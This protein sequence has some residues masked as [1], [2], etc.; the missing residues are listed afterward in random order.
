[1]TNSTRRAQRALIIGGSLGGLFTATTLRAIGWQVDVFERSPN[2]LDSRGGGIVLQADVEAAF[3]FAGVD[4]PDAL[5]VRSGDRIFLDKNDNVTR[6]LYMPQTQTS[7]NLL[8]GTLSRALPEGLVHRGESLVSVEKSPNGV[9]ARFASGRVETGD[10]LVGADGPMSAVRQLHL[11]DLVPIY[12]GYTARRGLAPENAVSARAER[13]L[14]GT[15]AFQD[16][17]GFQFL[18]YMVPGEDASTEV[19][20]RRWNWVWH[21]RLDLG[22]PYDDVMTDTQGR[23]RS[24]SIPP[25]SL[26]PEVGVRLRADAR[27]LLAPSFADLVE[28]T[29]EPFA[30]AILDLRVPRMVFDRTILLGDAAFVPR[31]HTAGGAAK[32]AANAV[33]LAEALKAFDSIDE[34]LAEWQDW[35]MRV[36]VEMCD[37]GIALGNSIVGLRGVRQHAL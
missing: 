27:E 36:G 17:P 19:G 11:P 20:R 28:A 26:R 13:T 10:L 22:A 21:R 23:R 2:A 18:A 15:F 4:H 1:M 30:Q 31:P 37:R 12:A 35:Q 8:H 16:G 29:E 7:W 6:R 9:T 34:A 24:F 5:G 14:G 3:Q 25:G 32:A 33:A